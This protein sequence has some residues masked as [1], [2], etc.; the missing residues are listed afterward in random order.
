[1]IIS[2]GIAVGSALGGVGAAAVVKGTVIA[3]IVAGTFGGVGSAACSGLV[4]R[5][6]QWPHELDV[7]LGVAFGL[8]VVG[9]ALATKILAALEQMDVLSFLK[10]KQ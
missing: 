2:E 10:P 9:L 5:Y 3:R 1:M 6:Y 8:A 7:E 4:I